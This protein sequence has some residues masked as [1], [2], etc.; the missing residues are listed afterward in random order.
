MSSRR[1][2]LDSRNFAAPIRQ[3]L[4]RAITHAIKTTIARAFFHS[5][6]HYPDIRYSF[7][8]L[9]DAGEYGRRNVE[10]ES[11]CGLAIHDDLVLGRRLHR[12]IG[13][14]FA[15]EDAIDVSARAR[16]WSRKSCPYEIKPPAATKERP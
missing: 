16:Y 2:R 15:F 3:I 11:L 6:G 8:H 12:Q 4:A 14:L 10:A 7:D 5:L 13:R 9:V 1:A